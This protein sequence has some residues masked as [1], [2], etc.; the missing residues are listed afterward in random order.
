MVKIVSDPTK[1]KSRKGVAA[2][3]FAVVAPLLLMFIIGMW[4]VGRLIEVTQIMANA[5]REAGRQAAAGQLT[6]AELTTLVQ[7][8]LAREGI[9]SANATLAIKNK[10]FTGN[11][12]PSDD[13]PR[14][15]T[16][17]D[18]LQMTVTLPFKDVRIINL[19]LVTNDTTTLSAQA[20]WP[21]M[22]DRA[23]TIPTPPTGS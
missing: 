6:P 16:D 14:N 21:S 4:E 12:A 10:G 18:Q 17:L 2:V 3:E 9:P 1:S 22:K 20:T 19:P 8:Y 23:Y 5:A 15:A 11:P 13:D 7:Q